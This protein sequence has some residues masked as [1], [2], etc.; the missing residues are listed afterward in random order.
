[1]KIKAVIF[2]FSGVIVDYAWHN[3][4]A[5]LAKKLRLQVKL[6]E[7]TID[8]FGSKLQAGKLSLAEASRISSKIYGIPQNKIKKAQISIIK[9]NS[10]IRRELV[11]L[12]RK[13]RKKGYKVPLLSNT[14]PLHAFV[15]KKWGWYDAFSPVILS[16]EVKAMKPQ[17]KIYQIALR[18]IGVSPRACVFIDDHDK[19][20]NTAKKL[21]MHTILFKNSKQLMSR[22]KK[23]GVVW[24]VEKT[25]KKA[26]S[27]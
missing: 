9:K 26:S 23:L 22:L 15:S 20:I 14:G 6:V 21:G 11:S 2:D 3:T 27:R 13:L 19:C 5:I 10:K 16:C 12:A 24:Q 7:R 4:P 17:K 18:K 8:R 1:M 25:S